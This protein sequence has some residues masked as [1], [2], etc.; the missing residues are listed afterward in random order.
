LSA[1]LQ[2]DIPFFRDTHQASA[3]LATQLA[4]GH[5]AK[6]LETPNHFGTD[7]SSQ[8]LV[9]RL[10]EVK[11]NGEILQFAWGLQP[12]SSKETH[13]PK[14][15]CHP[16]QHKNNPLVA[17]AT[18][19]AE[20]RSASPCLKGADGINCGFGQRI[21]VKQNTDSPVDPKPCWNNDPTNCIQPLLDTKELHNLANPDDPKVIEKIF[22]TFEDQ[23]S[24]TLAM[25]LAVGALLGVVALAFRY[26]REH[27]FVEVVL[28]ILGLGVGALICAYWEPIAQ[29]LTENGKGEPIAIA[30]GVSVWPTIL[31]RGLGIILSVYFFLRIVGGLHKNLDEIAGEM[32]LRPKPAPLLRQLAGIQEILTFLK[33]LR[34][35]FHTFRHNNGTARN[36]PLD[37]EAAW[38]TYLGRERIWPRSI[39]AALCT[40]LMFVFFKFVLAPVFGMT[41]HPARGALAVEVFYWT[42]RWDVLCMLFLTFFVFDATLSCL[43]FVNKLRRAQSL[44]PQATIGVYKGRLRL[45]TKLIHD[46]IDLDFVAKRTMCI[47]SLIYYPFV[48]I[49]LLIV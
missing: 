43:L 36:V 13:G 23:N 8:L 32:E 26:V 27:A 47:G 48:L 29:Y 19:L 35:L 21:D 30:D 1:W 45:Q 2:G 18:A 44:W 7:L 41:I 22:P 38:R 20:G 39:R 17:K 40:A 11:R 9:P 31:L 25:S 33:W 5:G 6:N 46:W 28:L 42:T 12:S 49:G 15:K 34:S 16:P 4:V 24:E 10:F 37:V 14:D 3:F